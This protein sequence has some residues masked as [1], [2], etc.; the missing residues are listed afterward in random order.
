MKRWVVFYI[1]LF[2]FCFCV[3][4]APSEKQD[5]NFISK[6]KEYTLYGREEAPKLIFTSSLCLVP[7]TMG[8]VFQKTKKA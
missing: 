6:Q 7:I 4:N 8:Y 1:L 2:L 3:F 5:T